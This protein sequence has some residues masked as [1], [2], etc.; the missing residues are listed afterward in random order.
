MKL[1]QSS[2]RTQKNIPAD[3]VSLNAKLL[4]RAGYIYKDMA[5]VYTQLPLGY[6][7]LQNIIQVIREEMNN[8]GGE[9]IFMPTL[10]NPEI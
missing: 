6:K 2:I 9:E 7:V 3:E 4:I 8:V 1:S 10:Q 5:G